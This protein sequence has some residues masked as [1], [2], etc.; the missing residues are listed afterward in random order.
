M[1]SNFNKKN[2]ER[3][4]NIWCFSILLIG[5]ILFLLYY[6]LRE[7]WVGGFCTLGLSLYFKYLLLC[8]IKEKDNKWEYW[9]H[10][11]NV[12]EQTQLIKEVSKQCKLNEN[13][14]EMSACETTTLKLLPIQ[15]IVEQ[16][17][18]KKKEK[19]N[20]ILDATQNHKPSF[21]MDEFL[22]PPPI[23]QCVQVVNTTSE[24]ILIKNES[25]V[26]TERL[27]TYKTILEVLNKEELLADKKYALLQSFQFIDVCQEGIIIY[28]DYNLLKKAKLEEKHLR[29]EEIITE[30]RK[31]LHCDNLLVQF[32]EYKHK[33]LLN[34]FLE[35]QK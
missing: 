10:Y 4:I 1:I 9:K 22:N 31:A 28:I 2:V 8:E 14:I 3:K 17:L 29:K 24:A 27:G 30:L 34:Y 15:T 7:D 20:P 16:E 6:L 32:A 5:S 11:N 25:S 35:N 12:E 33:S 19:E 18:E 21:T 26:V 23:Q 13:I